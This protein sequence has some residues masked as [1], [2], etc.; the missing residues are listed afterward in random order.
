MI[1]RAPL[2]L[3]LGACV[4]PGEAAQDLDA[5]LWVHEVVAFNPGPDAGFGADLMPDVVTGV[6][7]GAGEH[8]GSLDVVSLGTGGEIILAFPTDVLDDPGPDLVVFENAFVGWI[9]TGEVSVS[10]DGVEWATFPCDPASTVGCAGV[11]PVWLN[12]ENGLD[13]ADA[14]SGGDRFDLASVGVDAARYVRVR[15][16][17]ANPSGATSSGFDLDAIAG[18]R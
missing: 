1:W 12:R 3:S 13:P 17:G 14:A 8:A 4:T 5:A 6:P 11:S 2:I 9:E 15:D 10:A 18:L 16:T 7:D